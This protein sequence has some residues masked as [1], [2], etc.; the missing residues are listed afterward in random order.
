MKYQ[1]RKE[2]EDKI[3]RI[4][5]AINELNNEIFKDKSNYRHPPSEYLDVYHVLT[6]Q[7]HH[8]QETLAQRE[9]ADEESISNTP[10][11]RDSSDTDE[12]NHRVP[13][14]KLDHSP[15]SFQ[16]KQSPTSPSSPLAHI[17]PISPTSAQ[18]DPFSL[19]QSNSSVSLPTSATNPNISSLQV[20][21]PL[22]QN[23]RSFVEIND[24]SQAGSNQ[25]INASNTFAPFLRIYIG[26]STVVV[27]KKP[28][29]LRDVVSGKLKNRHMEIKKCIAYLKDT[30]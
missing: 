29:A 16:A 21:S 25:Q 27:E 18:S 15:K 10:P 22:G 8:L 17:F 4:Q 20:A 5:A 30:K 28:A 24:Q 3:R 7:L 9:S 13:I 26:N 11:S 14:L 1:E 12:Q 23:S 6:Q 19:P 2:T